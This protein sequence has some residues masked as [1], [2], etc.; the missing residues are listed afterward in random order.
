MKFYDERDL[1]LCGL[2]CVLCGDTD[3]L[4][5]KK[6]AAKSGCDCSVFKCADA[7]GLDGCYQCDCFPCDEGMFENVRV[8]AF[9]MYAKQFGKDKLLERLKINFENGIIYHNPDGSTGDYDLL[10]T[11][12]DIIRL[13]NGGLNANT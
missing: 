13:I 2:A 5:C 3:C 6:R 4:G 7:K 10:E 12:E 11:E 1:G 9:N 8:R